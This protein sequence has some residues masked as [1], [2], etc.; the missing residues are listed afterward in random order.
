MRFI[1]LKDGSGKYKDTQTGQVGYI[2]RGKGGG[3]YLAD[4][5]NRTSLG[6]FKKE[7]KYGNTVNKMIKEEPFSRKQVKTSQKYLGKYGIKGINSYNEDE[8]NKINPTANIEGGANTRVKRNWNK[9]SEEQRREEREKVLRQKIQ[10]YKD[11]KGEYE[12]YKRAK[13][14]PD[15]IDPMTENSTDWEA[16]DRKYKN[17]YTMEQGNEDF[18]VKGTPKVVSPQ[19]ELKRI[20]EYDAEYNDDNMEAKVER[21]RERKGKVEET[22]NKMNNEINELKNKI[23]EYKKIPEFRY[24]VSFYENELITKM[25]EKIDFEAKNGLYNKKATITTYK[26]RK[27]K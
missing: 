12:L 23:E 14:N 20:R 6:E 3:W 21:F 18:V 13:E 2:T 24:N 19:E 25:R 15:S 8:K 7:N 27:G 9:Y 11:K 22:I 1:P 5:P 17:R 4:T 26:R 16:L 10:D